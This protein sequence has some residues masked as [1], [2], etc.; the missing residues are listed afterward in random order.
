MVLTRLDSFSSSLFFFF[1]FL[2][3]G[4]VAYYTAFLGLMGGSSLVEAVSCHIYCFLLKL[5]IYV[6]EN[7]KIV[8]P[9]VIFS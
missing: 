8:N 1:L 2:V 9:L 4:F 5:Y 6:C 3:C 7:I